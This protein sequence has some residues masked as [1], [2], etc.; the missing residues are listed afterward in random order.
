MIKYLTS[1]ALFNFP[2]WSMAIG[3]LDALCNHPMAYDYIEE[4]INDYADCGIEEVTETWINDLLWFD[5][6]DI[7]EEA[8]LY[9]SE[10]D[11][12]EE[13]KE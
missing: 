7:L 6:F 2:A 3:N 9:D 4:F 8:G 5:L 13:D 12:W 1:C 10:K 11:E